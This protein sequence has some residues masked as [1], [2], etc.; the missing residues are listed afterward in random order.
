MTGLL[1]LLRYH[2][3]TRSLVSSVLTFAT[4][5]GEKEGK[6]DK[7]EKEDSEGETRLTE[8]ELFAVC[9]MEGW[10]VRQRVEVC[11]WV[12]EVLGVGGAEV[13][14]ARFLELWKKKVG[15]GRY[16]FHSLPPCSSFPPLSPPSFAIPLPLFLLF[17]P[18]LFLLTV[19][20]PFPRIEFLA[21]FIWNISKRQS[22]RS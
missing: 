5:K 22:H 14:M 6:D 8:N 11:E 19:F 17:L 4:K 18:S 2:P 7:K 1:Q 3:P 9:V 12:C 13:A 16:S 21:Y 15:S 10:S 20:F